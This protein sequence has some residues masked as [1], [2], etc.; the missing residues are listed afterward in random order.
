MASDYYPNHL[1]YCETSKKLYVTLKNNLMIWDM[2]TG[3]LMDILSLQTENEITAIDFISSSGL[4]VVG[5]LNG[6]IYI[7][8]REN[9]IKIMKLYQSKTKSQILHLISK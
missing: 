9:G 7:R 2:L 3:R 5:D 4:Y 8:K 6:A 1:K